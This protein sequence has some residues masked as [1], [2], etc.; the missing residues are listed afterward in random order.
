MTAQKRQ[1]ITADDFRRLAKDFGVS[2]PEN[3]LFGKD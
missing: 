2:L 1:T 3:F